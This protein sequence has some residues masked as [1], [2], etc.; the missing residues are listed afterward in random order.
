MTQ[1]VRRVADHRR[2]PDPV[3]PFERPYA[4]RVQP[5]HAHRG[6]RRAGRPVRAGRRAARRGRR[7]RGAQAQPRLQPDPGERARLPA[8]P[9]HPGLRHPA[10][11]R[12]RPGGGD[13]GRQ[14]DRARPDRRRHRRRRRHHLRRAARRSTRTCAGCCSSEP[15]PVRRRPAAGCSP[16]CGPASVVPEMPRN[17]EPRTGL[18]MGEHAAITARRVGGR[19][20]GPGRAGA[21]RP[22]A[23]RRR[24]RRGLLR[25]P[26]HAVPGADPRP[27]PAPGPSVE[28]LAKLKPVFGTGRGRD[29]DGRQ[30]DPAD[31]RR[32]GGAAGD[33]G[34]G[35]RRT[36]AGARAT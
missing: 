24:V 25:R 15:G 34:V 36:A 18:S 4:G 11:L 9:A 8:R 22:P 13:P 35:R 6:A 7:R 32:G 12:H 1:T 17:A 19:P 23:A 3:R 14:Q 27:E 16:G 20:R 28:K 21:R 30:L 2:Q 5:G 29:D 26:G 33:R 31:R 10:G